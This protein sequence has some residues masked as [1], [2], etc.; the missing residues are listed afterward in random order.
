MRFELENRKIYGLLAPYGIPDYCSFIYVFLLQ[1]GASSYQTIL[2]SHIVQHD[3]LEGAI[4]ILSSI[5][6]ISKQI[7]RGKER[8]YAVDP[9]ISWK[10]QEF[11]IIWECINEL[12][13]DPDISKILDVNDKKRIETIR[14]LRA[15]CKI[16]YSRRPFNCVDG[17]KGRPQFSE[18][19]YAQVCAE[20]ISLAAREIISVRRPPYKTDTLPISWSAITE[21]RA[22]GIQIRS[23]V[24]IEEALHHGLDVVERDV[25]DIGI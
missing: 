19:E 24:S 14:E 6:L 21:R 13:S 15:K 5:F 1:R 2:A 4:S 17:G 8:F 18:G 3:Q 9:N 22:A 10:W 20:T 11:K 25:S 16:M 23:Y 12:N 7:Y